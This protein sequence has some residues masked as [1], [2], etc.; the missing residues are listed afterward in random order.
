MD[1]LRWLVCSAAAPPMIPSECT[2]ISGVSSAGLMT[3]TLGKSCSMA[4]FRNRRIQFWRH[5]PS[6]NPAEMDDA[7]IDRG[8]SP[9][10]NAVISQQVRNI[11]AATEI[12][13]F[14]QRI[15]GFR[16][17]HLSTCGTPPAIAFPVSHSLLLVRLGWHPRQ[18]PH[19]AELLLD[20][21]PRVPAVLAPKQ[22]A[23]QATGQHQVGVC[24]V[25]RETTNVA[26]G[27]AG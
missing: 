17:R 14:K 23:I 6:M 16:E 2:V 21:P 20:L 22:L 11:W 10:A 7:M 5:A 12:L 4:F 18:R 3:A 24:G 19:L 9:E 27:L 13:P 25:G 15:V 8:L 1:K 26:V